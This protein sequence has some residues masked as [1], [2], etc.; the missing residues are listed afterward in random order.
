MAWLR[1]PGY[2]AGTSISPPSEETRALGPIAHLL[3]PFRLRE[4]E[5]AIVSALALV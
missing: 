2:V 3:K 4:L 5:A 1:R